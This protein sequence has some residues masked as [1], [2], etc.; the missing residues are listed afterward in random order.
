MRSRQIPPS[1]GGVLDA[2]LP[3]LAGRD[4]SG[5]SSASCPK[6]P[7][8]AVTNMASRAIIRIVMAK[9][10]KDELVA[11]VLP[12]RISANQVLAKPG[13]NQVL[14]RASGTELL[15]SLGEVPLAPR[16]ELV[17]TRLQQ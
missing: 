5:N 9:I 1:G 16:I 13:L 4:E 6:Q 10:W 11:G 8:A 14:A 17:D 7:V 12:R 3:L 2:L 15:Q